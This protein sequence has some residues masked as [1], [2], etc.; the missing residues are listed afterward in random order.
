MLV[1]LGRWF[2]VERGSSRLSFLALPLLLTLPLPAPTYERVGALGNDIGAIECTI[3]VESIL[4][5]GSFDGAGFLASTDLIAARDGRGRYYVVETYG[6][7]IKVFNSAGMY[8]Q[9][10]GREG[11]GPGEF[12]GISAISI[13]PGDILH[14]FDWSNMRRS[15][16][17]PNYRF[18]R[19][20]RLEI[21]PSLGVHRL[22]DGRFILA[23]SIRTPERIGSPLHL[24]NG[25][26]RVIRSFGSQSGIFRPDI[27]YMGRRAIGA[28]PGDR[29]W[30]GYRNRYAL[31]LWDASGQLIRT[32]ERDVDWFPPQLRKMEEGSEPSAPSPRLQAVREDAQGLLWV[33]ILVADSNWR[34]A[35]ELHGRRSIDFKTYYDTMVEVL[36]PRTGTVLAQKRLPDAVSGFLGD[37]LLVAGVGDAAGVPRLG[38]WRVSLLCP[39]REEEA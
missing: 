38:V 31:E 35:G 2:R 30:S 25:R 34:D 3:N 37:R 23:A 15:V 29:V 27:P 4:N 13:S 19:S 26:G 32:L 5:L 1:Q 12:M 39:N 7:E 36:D 16:F 20:V 17:G 28:A 18:V 21:Q 14:I 8:L 24:L 11:G 9:S 6:T 22:A 33:T 10:I